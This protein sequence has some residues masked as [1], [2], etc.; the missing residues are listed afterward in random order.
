[1]LKI[2]EYY[3]QFFYFFFLLLNNLEIQ[4]EMKIDAI[5][6]LKKA[7]FPSSQNEQTSIN[8]RLNLQVLSKTLNELAEFS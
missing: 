5:L 7:W 2:E 3:S 4:K 8:T 6:L 1:M